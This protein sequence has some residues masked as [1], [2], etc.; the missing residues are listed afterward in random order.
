MLRDLLIR[1]VGIIAYFKYYYKSRK[2]EG[3]VVENQT[4]YT[5]RADADVRRNILSNPFRRFEDM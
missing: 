4:A 2:A 3:L 1:L 5:P